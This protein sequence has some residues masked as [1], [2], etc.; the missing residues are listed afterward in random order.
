MKNNVK[1]LKKLID[2]KAIKALTEIG[3]FVQSE[4]KLRAPVDMG[5]LKGSIDFRIN[6]QDMAVT[7]GA[8]VDYAIF[9]E[10]GTG[11]YNK[12][13]GRKTPWVVPMAGGGFF[14]TSGQKAQPFL[15]PAINDNRDQLIKFV[16][17]AFK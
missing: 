16:E 2:F 5:A 3:M 13:D 4:A 15:M 8:G 10:K 17:Q 1:E 11:I 14:T 7:I 6:P 9:V 12:K